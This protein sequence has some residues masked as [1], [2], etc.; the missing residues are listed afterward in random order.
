MT[1]GFDAFFDAEAFCR[2]RR[3]WLR[4]AVAAMRSVSDEKKAYRHAA[5]CGR[6]GSVGDERY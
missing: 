2:L 4:P 6:L 5:A 1:K 3:S